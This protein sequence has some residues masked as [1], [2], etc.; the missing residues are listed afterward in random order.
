VA[1]LQFADILDLAGYL[2]HLFTFL[3]HGLVAGGRAVGHGAY[4]DCDAD[5]LHRFVN[6]FWP[7]HFGSSDPFSGLCG[8]GLNPQTMQY[9][10][11]GCAVPFHTCG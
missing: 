5:P 4:H 2:E 6:N 1:F 8:E 9:S 3:A 7:F 11:Q 10:S